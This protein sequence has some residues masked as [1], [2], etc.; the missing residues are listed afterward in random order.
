MRDLELDLFL[1]L[2]G[3]EAGRALHQIH[4]RSP[5]LPVERKRVVGSHLALF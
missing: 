5:S 4:N 2:S 1:Y 3:H